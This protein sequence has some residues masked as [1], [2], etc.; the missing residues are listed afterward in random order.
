M[1]GSIVQRTGSVRR[2][3]LIDE[4]RSRSDIEAVLPSSELP[5]GRGLTR[6]RGGRV[7]LGLAEHLCR[8][9]TALSLAVLFLISPMVLFQAGINYEGVGG[10]PLEKL[11]PGHFLIILALFCRIIA[12]GL[13]RF[14]SETLTSYPGLVLFLVTTFF[15]I[16]FTIVVQKAAFT[17]L[18]DTFIP[19]VAMFLILKD[20]PDRL[21]SRYAIAL[22]VVFAANALLALYEYLSGNRLTPYVAGTVEIGADDWRSTALFGH[23]LANAMLAGTYILCLAARG[24]TVP[25]GLRALMLLLQFSSLV[26]FGARAALVAT[27]GM[28]ALV[29][30]GNSLGLLMG[31]MKL[32]LVFIALAVMAVPLLALGVMLLDDAGFFDR[33]I[34]RFLE[35]NGS[36]SARVAMFELFKYLNTA[37]FL[38]GPDPALIES[39]KGIEGVEAGIESFWVAFALSYGLFPSL[40]FFT[41]LLAFTVT[42]CRQLRSYAFYVFFF[43][44]AVA[45]TSVSLS[46]KG[47]LFGMF[48]AILFIM[49]KPARPAGRDA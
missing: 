3:G 30:L 35:D 25:I 5:G 45:S 7:R 19:A 21:L 49:L 34:N 20:M 9:L 18:V 37:D 6:G 48:V 11:H 47:P 16:W 40:F 44:Y 12:R 26:A 32:P 36:A 15:L 22:H 10:S 2:H 13:G 46:A 28:F 38:F 24:S 43:F 17:P 39:L 42:I 4:G 8:A 23:P 14:L 41:G 31:R 29:M 33:L 1:P 27:I